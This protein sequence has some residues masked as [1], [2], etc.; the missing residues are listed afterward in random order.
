MKRILQKC[1]FISILFAS[2]ITAYAQTI[3]ISVAAGPLSQVIANGSTFDATAGGMIQNFSQYLPITITI[4]NTG[5][6]TLTLTETG[7]KYVVLGGTGASDFIV[8]EPNLTG[9]IAAGASQSFTINIS[10]SAN[11]GSNKIVSMTILSN[12][13]ANQTYSGSIKYN[14]SNI[15][16]SVTKASDIGLSLYPN[17]SNDGNFHV[18]ATNVQVSRIVVSNT[19]GVTEE[20]SSTDFKTNLKG[21]LLIQ[22]YTSKG[23]VSEKVLVQ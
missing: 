12:D 13:N 3:E 16:T 6:A 4:R 21:L 10:S 20:H 15:T 2:Y 11:N 17:P 7:G 14:F 23:L 22:L 8:E 9:S 5:A 19:A 18:K 1:C